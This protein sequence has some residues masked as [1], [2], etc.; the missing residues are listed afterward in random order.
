MS[1][2]DTDGLWELA[3]VFVGDSTEVDHFCSN[4]LATKVTYCFWFKKPVAWHGE[5]IG[6]FLDHTLILVYATELSDTLHQKL[7]KRECFS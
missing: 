5:M 3:Q 2:P 6:L 4:I 7:E 1:A